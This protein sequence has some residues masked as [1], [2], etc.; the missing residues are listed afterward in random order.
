VE[1]V[2]VVRRPRPRRPASRA[3]APH[4]PL[5][6][7]GA[8]PQVHLH[9][10]SLPASMPP[11]VAPNSWTAVVS[12]NMERDKS[13]GPRRRSGRCRLP[14][15]RLDGRFAVRGGAWQIFLHLAAMAPP[16]AHD[17]LRRL[18]LTD[19]YCHQ[20]ASRCAHASP[21]DRRPQ[22]LLVFPRMPVGRLPRPSPRPKS[23][24]HQS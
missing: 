2:N 22:S 4:L 20:A 1:R 24:G 9:S 21:H 19:H 13:L 17:H 14:R 18:P 11:S 16:T 7:T 10:R 3:G 15:A 12:G 6:A 23:S 5:P 8:L